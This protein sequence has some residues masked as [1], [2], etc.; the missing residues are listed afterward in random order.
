MKLLN[1]LIVFFMPAVPR[2]IVKQF[3]KPYIAGPTLEDAIRVTKQL[4]AQGMC[5]TL[6]VLGEHVTRR[7][8]ASAAAQAYIQALQAIADHRLDANVSLKLTQMGLKIDTDF[9]YQTVAGIVAEAARHGNFVRIDMED[10]SCTSDTIALY[11]RLREKYDNVGIVLQAYLRRTLADAEHLIKHK[12]NFRLCKGIYVEPHHLAWK[13]PEI[14]NYN[15]AYLAEL[16]LRNG[17][18]VGIATHDE[19]LIWHALRIIHT[20]GLRRD[21]YEFQMLLGVTEK[22][23]SILVSEGHRL[24]VYVPFGQ[25]W[26]AYSTRRLKENPQIAGY[27][28]KSLFRR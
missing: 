27:I 1:R 28:V 13:D 9:C 3:A 2:F 7:E 19:R 26:Y 22:L 24:R 18:Y 23:R 25:Q 11:L 12:T 4:N 20:L 10:S 17:C 8:E 5:A 16:I 6:D 14:V 15:F 21:Q